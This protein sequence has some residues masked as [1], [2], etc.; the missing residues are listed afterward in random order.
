MLADQWFFFWPQPWPCH[1]LPHT[2]PRPKK[3]LYRERNSDLFL[4]VTEERGSRY[5]RSE[6]GELHHM[7]SEDFL[8][9][10]SQVSIEICVRPSGL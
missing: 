10:P 8:P 3:G 9:V 6:Y 1:T 4:L 7:T 2:H 5:L